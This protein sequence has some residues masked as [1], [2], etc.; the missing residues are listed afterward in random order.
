MECTYFHISRCKGYGGWK[1]IMIPSH[2]GLSS[3]KPGAGQSFKYY[4]LYRQI[5]NWGKKPLK[6]SKEI[7]PATPKDALGESSLLIRQVSFNKQ[8]D[9]THRKYEKTTRQCRTRAGGGQK[10]KRLGNW[11]PF[12]NQ[13]RSA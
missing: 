6:S 1:P 12:V 4:P 10:F 11:T 2:K 5:S 8:L 9:K 13:S 7:N 3:K